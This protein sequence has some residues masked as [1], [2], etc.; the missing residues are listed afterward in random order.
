M[1][2]SEFLVRDGPVLGFT[3]VL[4]LADG[5]RQAINAFHASDYGVTP[6]PVAGPSS[7]SATSVPRVRSSGSKELPTWQERRRANAR[8]AAKVSA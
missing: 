4:E 6:R 7:G 8:G 2:Q 3:E 5:G 1:G